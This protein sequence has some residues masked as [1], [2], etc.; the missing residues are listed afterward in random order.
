[1]N[2]NSVQR[3]LPYPQQGLEKWLFKAP[4]VLWRLGL[5]PIVG[6]VTI[7]ITHWGRKS[8]LPRHTVTEYRRLGTRKYVPCAWGERSQ[9]YQNIRAN[10]H[11]TIQT[12]DGIEHVKAR[13]VIDDDELRAVYNNI[14]ASYAPQ[15]F[16]AYL[17]SLGIEPTLDDFL[18]NKA[19]VYFIIFEPTE[20]PTPPPL[21]ADLKA[22]WLIPAV[23]LTVYL[24]RSPRKLH[25]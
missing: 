15:L 1:M 18:A 23:V 11:V 19:H 21:P 6:Q 4:L 5:G 12:S 3:F 17:R 10:P 7:V 8:G 24:S 25:H 16:N 13:R 9:W 20:E 2:A 22:L 14:R